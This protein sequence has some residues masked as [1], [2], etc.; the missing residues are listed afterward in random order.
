[1]R[2]LPDGM[3]RPERLTFTVGERAP[4]DARRL[5]LDG[6]VLEPRGRSPGTIV[7]SPG[8]TEP[9]EHCT[10]LLEPLGD[11]FRVVAYSNRGHGRS[12]G[13]LEPRAAVH[14]LD[15]VLDEPVVGSR[16][17]LLG[18]SFW[19]YVTGSLSSRAAGCYW[20]APYLG[21]SFAGPL[22][23]AGLWLLQHAGGL[24]GMADRLIDRTGIIRAFGILL[25]HPLT[26]AR[27]LAEVTPVPVAV[28]LAYSVPGRDEVLSA[29]DTVRALA[30][31]Y[32][33]AEDHSAPVKNL[34]H[35]FNLGYRDFTALCRPEQGKQS[36]ALT[37]AIAGFSSKALKRP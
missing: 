32:P 24:V 2:Q 34:N 15:A 17:V 16:P 3:A 18:H 14:D 21:P 12:Q 27:G 6:Y 23:R 29:P 35:C 26:A 25:D 30:E 5:S 19:C 37:G 9:A 10:H 8:F 31:Q 22:Q 36:A 7:F 4:D 28:P 33:A 1:M 20:L 11:G 13:V